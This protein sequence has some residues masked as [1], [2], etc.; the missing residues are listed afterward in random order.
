MLCEHIGSGEEGGSQFAPIGD[1]KDENGKI[2]RYNNPQ[3]HLTAYSADGYV[4]DVRWSEDYAADDPVSALVRVVSA[5]LRPDVR[6][7][8][9]NWEVTGV[10]SRLGR[11]TV[12]L[13]ANDAPDLRIAEPGERPRPGAVLSTMLKGHMGAHAMRAYAEL[14]F[15]S[16][17]GVL[18]VP[19]E[20]GIQRLEPVGGLIDQVNRLAEE[21]QRNEG[22]EQLAQV[23]QFHSRRAA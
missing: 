8:I 21:S 6:E 13:E 1:Y 15:D 3:R 2:H 16:E 14:I 9:K 10:F 4:V 17:R 19:P 22:S 23:V 7:P 12:M 5:N 18:W 11:M 20:G